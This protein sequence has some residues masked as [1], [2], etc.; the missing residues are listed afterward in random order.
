M[1]IATRSS[2]VIEL[3][4]DGTSCTVASGLP[5][6]ENGDVGAPPGRDCDDEADGTDA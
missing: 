2:S 5:G 1:D 4:M 3:A 6:G